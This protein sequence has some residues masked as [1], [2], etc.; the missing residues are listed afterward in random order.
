M[1]KC[2]Q[3]KEKEKEIYRLTFAISLERSLCEQIGTRR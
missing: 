2:L 1:C 3:L